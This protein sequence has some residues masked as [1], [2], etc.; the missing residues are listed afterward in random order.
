MYK[1]AGDESFQCIT[2]CR[3]KGLQKFCDGRRTSFWRLQPA[4]GMQGVVQMDMTRESTQKYYTHTPAH[5]LPSSISTPMP[6]LPPSGPKRLL[7]H[8]IQKRSK[9]GRSH[10]PIRKQMQLDITHISTLVRAPSW[11]SNHTANPTLAT[12]Q[13]PTSLPLSKLKNIQATKY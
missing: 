8:A 6:L 5:A 9:P 12:L 2:V 1:I 10:N 13:S 4:S 7:L 3:C 11:S